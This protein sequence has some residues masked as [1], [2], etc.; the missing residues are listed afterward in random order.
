VSSLDQEKTFYERFWALHNDEDL[1]S[2][3]QCFGIGVFRRSSVLEGFEKFLNDTRFSGKRCVEIGTCNGLTAIVL[4]RHF[5]EVITIDI[6]PNDIKRRIASHCGARNITFVDVANNAEKAEF[7]AGFNFDA[8]YVDGDHARD[9]QSDFALVKKCGRVLFHEY[10]DAQPEVV[11]L[12]GSLRSS[13]TVK[14]ERKLALWT[15]C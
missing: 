11:Q 7:L 1:L 9:T 13:G 2:V 12:V 6:A 10:W 5:K 15:A 3:F 4:A 8:A 14:T